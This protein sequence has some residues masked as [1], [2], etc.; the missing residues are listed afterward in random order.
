MLNILDSQSG[1][2]SLIFV[3]IIESLAVSWGYGKY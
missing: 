2:I 3:A 1:G